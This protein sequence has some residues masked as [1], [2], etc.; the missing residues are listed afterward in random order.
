[1]YVRSTYVL[2]YVPC[3]QS[4]AQG[5]SWVGLSQTVPVVVV[6][7]AAAVG[8]Q[9]TAVEQTAAVSTTVV[10]MVVMQYVLEYDST[11]PSALIIRTTPSTLINVSLAR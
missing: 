7:V 5:N 10:H 4:G 2:L 9:L 3:T 8:D 6:V 11:T 1:M